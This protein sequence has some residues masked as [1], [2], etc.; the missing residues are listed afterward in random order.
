[1]QKLHQAGVKKVG[2][3]PVG[4]AVWSIAAA[5]Q[6]Q[7]KSQRAKIEGSIGALKSSKYAFH[8]GR[9]RTDQSLGATGQGALVCLN[10]NKLLRDLVGKAKKAHAA[11]A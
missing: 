6:Q 1:V 7:G 4:Y 9:Q 10:V 11:T 3:E 8:Q 5:D 2:I